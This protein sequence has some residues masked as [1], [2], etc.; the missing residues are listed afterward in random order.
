MKKVLA[1]TA[2]AVM[3]TACTMPASYLGGAL[4]AQ[5]VEPTLVTPNTGTKTGKACGKNYLG[6]FSS[7]DMSVE[8]AK[9]NGK[10]KTVASVDREVKNML[11]VAEVCT[12]VTGS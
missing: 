4:I 6:I 3:L 2:V 12:V 7:G 8:A 1:L 9:A 11:V 5:T 10:I